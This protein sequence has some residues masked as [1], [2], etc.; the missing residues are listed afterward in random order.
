MAI[1]LS[2]M[3]R[4]S[5]HCTVVTTLGRREVELGHSKSRFHGCCSFMCCLDQ[6]NSRRL[7]RSRRRKSSSVPEGGADFPAA[8]FLAGKSPN[9]GRDSISS[10]RKSGKNFPAASKFAGK[11]SSNEFWAATAFSSFLSTLRIFS[12]YF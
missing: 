1:C 3:A 8:I 9:L 7:W 4:R 11:F 5:R 6:E 12:G 10:C 2:T